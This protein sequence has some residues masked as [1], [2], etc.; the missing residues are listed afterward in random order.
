MKLDVHTPNTGEQQ[1]R[2]LI[3]QLR[4]QTPQQGRRRKEGVVASAHSRD[5]HRAHVRHTGTPSCPFP[6]LP[7]LVW[8]KKA[9]QP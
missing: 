4:E 7:E 3:K 2:P 6:T 8:W 9:F 5:G 1:Q